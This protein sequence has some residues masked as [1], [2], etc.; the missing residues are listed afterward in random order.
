MLTVVRFLSPGEK[1]SVDIMKTLLCKNPCRTLSFESSVENLH[2][3]N[4]EPDIFGCV[5]CPRMW[6]LPRSLA[7][8][9]H[10]AWS[11]PLGNIKWSNLAKIWNIVLLLFLEQ[12][13]PAFTYCTW[14]LTHRIHIIKERNA[15][16][17]KQRPCWRWSQG[18]LLLRAEGW[19]LM[20]GWN[21]IPVVHVLGHSR[22]KLLILYK[23][24]KV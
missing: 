12:T 18:W 19:Y 6:Y 2:L 23:C 7:Q 5:S 21:S 10:T 22:M 4:R 3:R 14:M 17:W 13:F 15:Q 24:I 16:D 8:L 11:V 9:T 20:T 1:R